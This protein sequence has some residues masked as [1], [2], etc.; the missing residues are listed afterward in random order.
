M[1]STYIE[2]KHKN[3]GNSVLIH[4]QNAQKQYLEN[5]PLKYQLKYG[6]HFRG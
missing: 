6:V 5:L 4:R 1:R 2:H 3:T